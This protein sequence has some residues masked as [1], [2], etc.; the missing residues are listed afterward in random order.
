[1]HPSRSKIQRKSKFPEKNFCF[2]THINVHKSATTSQSD[3]QRNSKKSI[4]LPFWGCLQRRSIIPIFRL[5]FLLK[6]GGEKK[7]KQMNKASE[8][9]HNFKQNS[10]YSNNVF[11]SKP[12]RNDVWLNENFQFPPKFFFRL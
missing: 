12:C 5:F 8:L 3:L 9:F 10:K 2:K 6:F 7:Q 11:L 4:H 1:M